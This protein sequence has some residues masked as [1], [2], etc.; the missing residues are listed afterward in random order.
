MLMNL[1]K[2]EK[3]ANAVLYE[4]YILY[5]YRPSAIKN[6]QRWNFGAV[7]PEKFSEM[8]NGTDACFMQTECL[9][10]GDEN[11]TV[12]VK[13]R[14]LQM[15]KRE[16]GRAVDDFDEKDFTDA[17]FQNV[18]S[19]EVGGRLF[20]SWQEA[21][22]RE[23]DLP[24]LILSEAAGKTRK[25][26][27]SFESESENEFLRDEKVVGIIVRRKE[28][29]AGAVEIKVEAAAENL[30]KLHIRISNE[31]KFDEIQE[32]EDALMRAFVST[33]TILKANNGEFVSLLDPPEEFKNF[34]ENCKNI[35]AFPVL[36]GEESERDFVLS[37]PI[38]LYDY[39]QIAPESMGDYFDGT[40]ID[41][42]LAL[43]IMTLTDDEK[44]QMRGADERT[45]AMLE[46][47]ETMSPELM[48]KLHGTSK[49]DLKKVEEK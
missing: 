38:I 7:Y 6:Q 9:I 44:H 33:H 29:I 27:F 19:L 8:Q 21:V 37:S 36:V 30:Y 16:V 43:R 12:D 18:Q 1:E 48:M 25:Y 17:D 20:Q 2:V 13:I 42:M 47:T 40:E 35:G 49:R 41:E 11:T 28:L 39:P 14:F 32:R 15:V 24:N 4:G 10:S 5:P 26:D 34:A 46:R 23:F 22:E 31:T 45:R 3:I